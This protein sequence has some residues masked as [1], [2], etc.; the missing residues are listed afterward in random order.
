MTENLTVEE[1]A[2]FD[3]LTKPDMELTGKDRDQVKQGAKTLLDRLKQ[4][5]LVIDRRKREQHQ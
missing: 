1:P 4:E 2:L 3:L 5:E